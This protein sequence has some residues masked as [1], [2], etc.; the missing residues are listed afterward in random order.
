MKQLGAAFGRLF[1]AV[2]WW[3]IERGTRSQRQQEWRMDP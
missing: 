3:F 2:L 1:D